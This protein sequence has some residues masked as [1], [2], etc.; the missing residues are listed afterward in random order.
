MRIVTLEE[1]IFTPEFVE[2]TR[3]LPS[4]PPRE[5]RAHMEPPLLDLGEGRLRAMDASGI[6][7]QVLSLAGGGL[8]QLPPADAVTLARGANQQIAAAMRSYPDRFSGFATVALTDVPSAVAE[9]R[10]AIEELGFVGV[11]VNG[12]T[13]GVFLDDPQFE[14]FWAEA[15]ALNIPVYLHPA[16]PP[17]AVEQAYFSGLPGHIGKMLS[18]AAWGWHA[19]TGLH[20][21]RLIAS[22]LFDRHSGLRLII[23]HMGEDLPFSIARASAVLENVTRELAHP[24]EHYFKHHFWLTTSGYFT[25]PPFDC[26]R[27]VL[28][29]D[30]LLFSIDYPFSPNERGRQFLDSLNL[31]QD[32]LEKLA[33]ANADRLL[34][35]AS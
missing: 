35:L 23:G 15:E 22:G 19:E 4:G 27:A 14:P 30:R 2:A 18:I 13:R 26:A 10:R 3:N 17:S 5:F 28:G 31:P 34:A 7:L 33:H 21:L 16:P 1:H 29:I 9:L 32:E 24:V 8:D 12:T 6:T 11:M 25:R 20:C